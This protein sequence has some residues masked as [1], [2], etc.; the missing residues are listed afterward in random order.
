MSKQTEGILQVLALAALALLGS[1]FALGTAI[2][3]FALA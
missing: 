1:S 2:A 3:P